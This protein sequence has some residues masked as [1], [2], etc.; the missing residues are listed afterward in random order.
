MSKSF[1]AVAIAALALALPLAALADT[2]LNL[3]TGTTG[4]SGGDIL[5][6]P[7]VSIAPQGSAKLDDL[8]TYESSLFGELECSSEL[9]AMPYSTTPISGADLALN[10]MFLVH[11]NGGNYAAVE[12]TAVS[13]TS[14]TMQYE[15]CTSASVKVEKGTATLGAAAG[16]TIAS[17]LNNYSNILPNAPNYGMAPGTLITIY[18]SSLAAPGSQ[19][20]LPSPGSTLPLTL[21]GSSVS[22]KVNGT[23]VQPAFYYAIPGQLGV[24]LPSSTP[25]GTGTITVSYGGQT[26][27]AVPIKVVASAFGFDYWGGALAAAT[28]NGDGHLITTSNS[29]YPAEVIVFWGAGVG[30]DTKNTDVS[31]PTHYDNLSGI[32]ALYFGSVQVPI[33]YQ[34]RSPYQGVD[35]IAVTIPSNA[36]TGCAVSIAAVSGSGSSAVV[37]N[38]VTLPI[39]TNGGTCVDPLSYFSP[40]QSSTLSGKT[41]VKFGEVAIGQITQPNATLTGTTTVDGADAIFESISGASLTGYQSSGR[42]SLGSCYVTQSNSST[43]VSPFTMTGL[44]AGS[45]SVQGPNGSQPLT[46]SPAVQGVYVDEPLPSGFIPSSGGT[47]TFTGTGGSDVGV[48]TTGVSYPG[49]LVWTNASSVGTVTRSQGVTVNWT[50]GGSGFVEIAGGSIATS[51]SALFSAAFVCDAAASAGTFTVPASVLLALPAGTGSLGVSN[52]TMPQSFTASGL[53]FAFGLSYSTTDIEATYN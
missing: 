29:A 34:G 5:F 2:T 13:S 3:D 27:A 31:P 35:Q 33:A 32:T 4:S 39:A 21:N 28:D 44:N 50:G 7:G 23:T 37:S 6:N 53:D 40:T 42:P 16:P 46:K 49:S 52:Y 38:F 17:V 1:H 20:V 26:S 9:A 30:A 25:V 8:S 12:L 18:G 41:T 11:T 19:A 24:V 47:F 14:V 48:F 10:E 22:V 43:V 45:V 36:P 15:T 51:T